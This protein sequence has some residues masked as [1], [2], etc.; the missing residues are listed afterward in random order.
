VPFQFDKP[1][2]AGATAVTG[3]GPAGVPIVLRDVTFA[4]S[5]LATSVIDQNNRFEFVLEAP[6]EAN[7]RIGLALDNLSETDWQISDFTEA[8]QGDGAMNFPQIDFF[9]DTYMIRE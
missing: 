1:V 4:G 5:L 9:F 7:H 3:R 6:L 2:L 8:Y